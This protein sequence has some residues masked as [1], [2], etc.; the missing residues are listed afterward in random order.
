VIAHCEDS[1]LRSSP[2]FISISSGSSFS[3]ISGLSYLNASSI[4]HFLR[5]LI[6]AVFIPFVDT[7]IHKNSLFVSSRDTDTPIVEFPRFFSHGYIRLSDRNFILGSCKGQVA[8]YVRTARHVWRIILSSCQNISRRGWTASSQSESVIFW[9]ILYALEDISPTSS[10]PLGRREDRSILHII[11]RRACTCLREYGTF[12]ILCAGRSADRD[13]W[14][15]NGARRRPLSAI[16]L[17][18]RHAQL[19]P[20]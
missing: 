19:K 2:K 7:V 17:V 14:T 20:R 18:R 6:S 1:S 15:C 13:V 5:R 12:A 3:V 11:L 9:Q 16:K 10:C 8:T 4:P